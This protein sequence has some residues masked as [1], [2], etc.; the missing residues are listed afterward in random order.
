MKRIPPLPKP[1]DKSEDNTW[2]GE[3]GKIVRDDVVLDDFNENL[4]ADVFVHEVA[5]RPAM[6]MW[7]PCTASKLKSTPPQTRANT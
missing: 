6:T 1:E 4:V 5:R 7:G 3:S 2:M